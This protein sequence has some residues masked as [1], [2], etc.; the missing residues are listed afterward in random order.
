MLGFKYNQETGKITT[1][2]GKTASGYNALG[3]LSLMVNVDGKRTRILG[4]QFAW[5]VHSGNCVEMIDHINGNKADNRISNLRPA[6]YS[7]NALN[8]KS[9]IGV[10]FCKSSGKYQTKIM[11]NYKSK[12]LGCFDTYNEARSVYLNYKEGIIDALQKKIK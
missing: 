9:A 3:Y 12:H 5:Y 6:N 4:H 7:L 1:P 11:L 10:Y 8:R 2:R